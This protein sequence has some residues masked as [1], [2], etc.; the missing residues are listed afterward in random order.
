MYG[1]YLDFFPTHLLHL[2]GLAHEDIGYVADD[3]PRPNRIQTYVTIR[4]TVRASARLE[5]RFSDNAETSNVY[6][7]LNK[8]Y[9]NQMQMHISFHSIGPP[10]S[11]VPFTKNLQEVL[12]SYFFLTL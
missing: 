12:E 5:N 11:I 6:K 4:Y 2:L 7:T 8:I 10:H 3:E 9:V 1:A